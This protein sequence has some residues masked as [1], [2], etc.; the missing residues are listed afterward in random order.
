M[1]G[2]LD[3]FYDVFDRIRNGDKI[4]TAYYVFFALF[5][6]LSLLGVAYQFR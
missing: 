4:E 3:N 6:I 2:V 1:I 5:I